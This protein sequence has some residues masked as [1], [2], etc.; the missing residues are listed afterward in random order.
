FGGIEVGARVDVD[1]YE[2]DD[3]RDFALWKSPKEGEAFWESPI[4][5]GRPGWHIACSV[6]SMKYLAEGFDLHAG[7]EDLT[8]PHHENE[9]A[10]SE[11]LTG[12]PF[13]RHWMH[14]RFLLVE[15]E[16]M[17]K[18]A[19]NFFTLRDLLVKGH[20]ASSIRFLL[21]SVPYRKQ[22]NFTFAGLEQAAHSVERLRTFETRMRMTKLPA[23]TNP[24]AQ[25][26]AAKAK[27]EMRAGMEDDLNT[28]RAS[29]AIFDMVREA[30]TMADHG[31]LREGD[32]EPFLEA[33][34]QFDEIFAVLKDDD[35]PKMK[36]AMEWAKAHGV[37]VEA[38]MASDAMPDEQVNQLIEERNAAKKARDF[39][40]SDAIRKQ[41]T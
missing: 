12:K 40:K 39:A 41:L 3:A 13:A 10:Q 31:E 28:A 9:I 8:F 16:K 38:G 11:S 5:P 33:L 22:L 34:Q 30:N 19:G 23:G 18:S 1:E 27:Q 35:A 29:A 32:K 20:K 2:K 7:G 24:A 4:G 15:G 37:A 14:V 26:A 21:N 17:S 36:A 6:M 25:E